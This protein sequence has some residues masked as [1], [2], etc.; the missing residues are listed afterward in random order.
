MNHIKVAFLG[1]G[2][3]ACNVFAGLIVSD[4][5]DVVEVISQPDKPVGRKKVLTPTP[6]KSYAS[7]KGYE[8]LAA[9]N[10]QELLTL[11]ENHNLDFLIVTDYGVLLTEEV[12]KLPKIDCLNVHASLLPQYRG[13]SPIQA[14]LLNGD[15]ETGI[16]V[17][18]LVKELDAGPIYSYS[19]LSV[20]KNDNYQSLLSKLGDLG[21]RLLADTLIKIVDNGIEP[22]EQSLA[23]VS[24]CKKIEKRSGLIEF[25]QESA[26][27]IYNKFRA[28]SLW[29]KV[30]FEYQGKKIQI[31]AMNVSSNNFEI[32]K[33]RVFE[34]QLCVGTLEGGLCISVIKPESKSEM[35]VVDF[36]R[37]N[38]DFFV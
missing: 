21:G 20:E 8:V 1:S 26:I 37:G 17:M 34:G 27:S 15:D 18:S 6:F 32:G 16:T 5:F 31:C 10:S 38:P 13:A 35:S 9:S 28:Y 24:F 3:F 14:A 19:K 23:E 29:P 2:Q 33:F 11:L 22:V 4:R 30:Y 36:I 25:D 12:I 7:S